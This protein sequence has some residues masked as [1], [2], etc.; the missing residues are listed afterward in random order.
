M[1]NGQTFGQ[2]AL[3]LLQQ[4]HIPG[5]ALDAAMQFREIA[6]ALSEGRAVVQEVKE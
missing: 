1:M 4:A 3:Q 2:L 6:K 5:D